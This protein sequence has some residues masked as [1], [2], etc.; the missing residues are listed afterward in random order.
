MFLL[1][2]GQSLWPIELSITSLPPHIR[3]NVEYLLLGGV[4]LGSVKPD[5]NNILQP[6][7]EK[8]NS[9]D[10]SINTPEGIKHLKAKLLLGV[11]DLPAKA[12]AVNMMQYNGRYGCLYCLDEGIYFSH[13]R[14]YLPSDNHRP[15]NMK[16]MTKWAK[17]AIEQGRPVFGVKGPSILSSSID[18]VKSVPIDYMHAILEGITKSLFNCWFN[19]KYHKSI[20]YLG[21]KVT[22]INSALL[23]IKPPGEFRRTPR[24]IETSK[25]W[26]A[27]EYRAWLLFYSIPILMEVGFP[28]DYLSHFSL[29]VSSMHILLNSCISKPRLEMAHLMLTRFYEL[30]PELY[31]QTMCS[32]NVHSVI[33]LCDV[34]RQ[35]GPLWCY[36]TFGF[37]NL[38]GYIKK[39]CHGTKNVLPQLI[40]SVRMRQALPLLKKEMN[41]K[42]NAATL[43]FLEKV[44]GEQRIKCGPLGK[45]VHCTLNQNELKAIEEAGLLVPTAAVPTYPRF[46]QQVGLTLSSAKSHNSRNNSICMICKHSLTSQVQEL[47]GSI[48]KFLLVNGDPIAIVSIF[49]RTGEEV[50][51][52]PAPQHCLS[53]L[54]NDYKAA[55]MFNLFAF[56]VKK[57]SLSQKLVAVSPHDLTEKCVHIPIKYSPNDIIITLPNTIEHH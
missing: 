21:K 25:Y 52:I 50:I 12:A 13:R 33:H 38:N 36:S 20:Y 29:L 40:Q 5:M 55:K 53:L 51:S 46:K 39:H 8:V 19:S 37:E 43:D 2:I 1:I 3:M 44:C 26:K 32:L 6:I 49:E 9:L 35:W 10:V 56:K 15:R 17:Q 7:I 18:I 22:A 47:F 57:L 54:E 30:I 31:P 14:L 45:I 34:V 27:C 16:D 28:P 48:Q 24:P 4:W 23:R 41:L 11:F 42:E